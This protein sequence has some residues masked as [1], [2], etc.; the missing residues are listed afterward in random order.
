MDLSELFSL[1][2]TIESRVN[3]YWTF[4]SVS[5]FAVTGWLFTDSSGYLDKL[6]SIFVVLGLIV[7][8]AANLSVLLNSTTLSINVHDEIC[9]K[10]QSSDLSDSFKYQVSKGRLK[11]R[12][13]LTFLMHIAID[14]IIVVAVLVTGW[15]CL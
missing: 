5:I 14:L 9:E 2:E 11:Y 13:E 12:L 4:W 15:R 8:F 1:R 10:A 3:Q 7:F 6:N